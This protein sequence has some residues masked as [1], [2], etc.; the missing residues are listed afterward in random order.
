MFAGGVH[1]RSGSHCVQASLTH[2][3]GHGTRKRDK[4][5][6]AG[7]IR[8]SFDDERISEHCECKSTRAVPARLHEVDQKFPLL[9][10]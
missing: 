2:E 6:F 7:E 4:N 1:M 3:P 8:L 9:V 5:G 10:D